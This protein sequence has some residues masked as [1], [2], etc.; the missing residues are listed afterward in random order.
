LD[1]TGWSTSDLINRAAWFGIGA[2]LLLVVLGRVKP[3]KNRRI[4][5]R[6]LRP[7]PRDLVVEQ[8]EVPLYRRPPVWQ[9]LLS[10]LGLGA[11]S[12][13]MGALLA[14]GLSLLAIFVVTTLTSLLK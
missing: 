5:V 7:V 13:V 2:V 11:L 14:I 1:V 3:A 10:F 8:T 4:T 12:T 9:R 6:G